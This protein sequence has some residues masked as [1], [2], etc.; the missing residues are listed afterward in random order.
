[1]KKHW[2]QSSFV[3]TALFMIVFT[4]Q[5]AIVAQTDPTLLKLKELAASSSLNANKNT[6]S[7]PL[8][9]LD[10]SINQD[11]YYIGGGDVFAIH[12]VEL[13][14]VEYMVV[15]DQNCD[16][17]IPDLGIARLGKKTL[18]QAKTILCDFVRSKLKKPYEVYASLVRSKS[19]IITVSGAISNPGTYQVEGTMRLF[20]ILQM[21]NNHNLPSVG[22]F[23]YREVKV[24]HGDSSQSYDLLKF[25]FLNDNAQNPYVYPGD[26]ICINYSNRRIFISGSLRTPYLGY[27]PIKPGET[28]K[29]FLSLFIFDC[30][31]DSANILVTK[32][33]E[34]NTVRT[35]VFSL[36]KPENIVL[37]D[38]D[39]ILVSQKSD[40]PRSCLV[41]VS[42]EAKRPGNYAIKPQT[43]NAM[44]IIDVAGG[45]TTR[46]NLKRAFI[47][48]K[49]KISD[50]EKALLPQID[51]QMPAQTVQRST[52]PSVVR[53][54]VAA[55]L[56]NI[57]TSKDFSI[58]PLTGDPKLVLLEAEDEV[59]IPKIEN[60]VYI[61]GNI[62][63]P[64]AYP[65]TAGHNAS[66]YIKQAGGVTGKGD[67]SNVFLMV[68]YGDTYQ[69]K[70]ESSVEEGDVIVVPESQ[71]YKV[72]TTVVLPIVSIVLAAL[73]TIILMYSVT[74]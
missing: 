44:S 68:Q 52:T 60:V 18:S 55:A 41:M 32:Y 40:Y 15:V 6:V 24:I 69:V 58:I 10:N 54:E 13:P 64:G 50:M 28:V 12:V 66:Y 71:Q 70:G 17:V 56:S 34:D 16:A 14:S 38:R 42:G 74:K 26:N 65:F 33:D 51:P 30:S 63:S 2:Q 4:Y 62:Q 46:G 31:A 45:P 39:V 36:K 11:S 57:T 27:L 73:S 5:Y 59:H 35:I 3:T 61:S 47:I 67:K 8:V 53:P 20:D 48:R 72:L 25:L 23:N 7:S 29:D 43:T 19:A 9:F 22:E 49:R 37:N 21:S 1:V